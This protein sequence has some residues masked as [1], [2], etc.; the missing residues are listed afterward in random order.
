MYAPVDGLM[1]PQRAGAVTS[2]KVN[3]TYLENDFYLTLTGLADIQ[4]N[5][6]NN[7]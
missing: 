3:H 5:E 1:R 2:G 7:L 6:K 4:M